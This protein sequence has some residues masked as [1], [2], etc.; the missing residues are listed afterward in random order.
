MKS[1][2]IF[3][4]GDKMLVAVCILSLITGKN[5]GDMFLNND[6]SLSIMQFSFSGFPVSEGIQ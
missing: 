2:L 3:T 5:S 6:I 1:A 4:F